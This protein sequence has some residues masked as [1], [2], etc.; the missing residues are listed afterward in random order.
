M[1]F[2]IRIDGGSENPHF[3]K[4]GLVV[5]TWLE[6]Q[7]QAQKG[8]WF[9]WW[10]VFF[11]CGIGVYFS[12]PFEPP[13]I[14]SIF[15][16]VFVLSIRFFMGQ[17]KLWVFCFLFVLGFSAAH[18]R[19][20]VVDAPILTKKINFTI[21]T[22][23]VA[24]IDYLEEGGG[25]RIVLDNIAIEEMAHDQTPNMVRLRLRRDD[26]I[27]IG[28]VLRVQASLAPP[29]LPLYPGGF[30]FRRYLYFQGI[31]AVGFI[32]NAPEII[33]ETSGRLFD[34]QAL[35][36]T[37]S[38]KIFAVLPAREA[39]I[40]AALIVGQKNAISDADRDAVRDAGLAHMLAIS[41][42]HVGLLSGCV[43]FFIRALLACAPVI[44]LRY[45]IKKIAAV[46]A[47]FMA[48]FYMLIAGGTVPTQ[49]AVMMCG[50]VFMAVVLDR[51]PISLR[52]VAFSALFVLAFCPESLV[53]ASFQMSFAAVTCLIF[54]YNITR[55][56]WIDQ[57]AQGGMFRKVALYFVGVCLT[58]VIASVATAPFALYHFGQVSFL[59]SVANL[60][61]VPLLAFIVMPFAF[62]AVLL[63]PLGL[64][65]IPFFIVEQGIIGIL[66]ISYWAASLPMAIMR[67]QAVDHIWFL[68]FILSCLWM[69]LWRGIVRFLTLPFVFIAVFGQSTY[70]LPDILISEKHKLF[71]FKMNDQLYVSSMRS[72]RFVRENW[73][74]F[75]GFEE[76]DAH[77]LSYKSGVNKDDHHIKCDYD[78]CRYM[79]NGYK[80]SFLKKP[81]AA[82]AEC[83]WA[84]VLISIE[85]L[86]KATC[87]SNTVIDKFDTSN[88]GAHS[89]ALIVNKEPII[90]Y[91]LNSDGSRPWNGY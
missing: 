63:M 77:L 67:V 71:A 24:A 89:I 48:V 28:Q 61:A 80:I 88:R 85:P 84:D 5:R 65:W 6:M 45:P 87:E 44:A 54:F 35:R 29:S 73:L 59:G 11:A 7:V 57:Y 91:V 3:F 14:F 56:F 20:T 83:M 21:L 2:G 60:I 82:N 37:I 74:Q 53:S 43:F 66:D 34:V 31:G 39:A 18:L 10:P 9:L 1:P 58:T 38:E 30:D 33:E 68:V 55:K 72:E 32:Y 62:L 8:Q 23:R 13:L 52:L 51:S 17:N 70:I 41:G 47:F 15:L 46:I 19:T 79:L 50:V 75:Y 36:Q 12:L 69:I 40:A 64:D 81:Y 42:L 22:G 27:K 4:W 90:K 86:K 26:G 16:C 49:R 25:S 78:A 76:D